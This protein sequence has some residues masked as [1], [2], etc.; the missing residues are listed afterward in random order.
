MG[1]EE[2]AN[3]ILTTHVGSLP[4]PD[5]LSAMMADGQTGTPE[6]DKAVREAVDAIVRKQAELGIDIVDDG[7]QSKP[8][9]VAYVL[10]RLAGFTPRD[11]V[12]E[13]FLSTRETQAFPEFYSCGHSGSA[14]PRMAT[15][16]AITYVGQK[17][18]RADIDNLRAALKNV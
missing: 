14:L 15:T 8:G 11:D 7:E 9:F 18:L 5:A 4:R 10:E 12:P 13:G 3:R 17:Q 16:K 6:F 2:R 1:L